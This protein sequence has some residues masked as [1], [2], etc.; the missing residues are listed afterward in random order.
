MREILMDCDWSNDRIDSYIKDLKKGGVAKVIG[1]APIKIKG[2]G[3]RQI[4]DFTLFFSLDELDNLVNELKKIKSNSNISNRQALQDAIITTGQ[5]ILG[6]MTKEDILLMSFDQMVSQI[7]GVPITIKS[8]GVKID[9]IIISSK[10]SDNQLNDIIF[11]FNAKLDM[12]EQIKNN[13]KYEGRF[14]TNGIVYFW[15]PLSIMPGYC[16]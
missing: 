7:F 12:L 11:D 13:S 10:V 6:Q 4:F 9:D 1:F 2:A 8:C 15:L 14:F 5:A 3:D 16:P